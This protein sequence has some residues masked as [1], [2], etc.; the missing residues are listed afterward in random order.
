MTTKYVGGCLCGSVR[1]SCE[2]TPEAT[3][4][5]HCV[6]CQKETGGPYSVEIYI[7][8][9]TLKVDGKTTQHDVTADSG[10][11]VTREFCGDCGS[12]LFLISDGYPGYV[13]I[14]AG[15]LDDASELKPEMHIYIGSKLPWVQLSDGL[16]QYEGDIPE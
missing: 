11:K 16:P 5:C 4:F 7:E 2:G 6:D 9:S 8:D 12:A 14:K 3:F 10:N 13:C 1:Y 15:S